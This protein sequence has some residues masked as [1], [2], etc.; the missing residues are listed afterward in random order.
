M[1]DHILVKYHNTS[2][3][4]LAL[5]GVVYHTDNGFVLL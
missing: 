3:G 2:V 1:N 4:S 5:G